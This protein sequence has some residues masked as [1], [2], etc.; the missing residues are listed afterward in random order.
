MK[1]LF[2]FLTLIS[3]S[4]FAQTLEAGVWKT[5][6]SISLNGLPLPL[7]DDETCITE[8]EA[9]DPQA[10]ITAG[11]K[12]KKCDLTKW[13]IKKSK[14]VAKIDCHGDDI[15]AKG[16]IQG[17]VNSKNYSLIGEAEGTYKNAIPSFAEIK[18]TGQW[19]KKCEK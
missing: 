2:I 8:A 16:S 12:K 7:E 5:K 14:L 15:Q 13:E 9:N 3:N 11:L 6:T 18:L 17:T 10:T 4:V 19:L 1:N